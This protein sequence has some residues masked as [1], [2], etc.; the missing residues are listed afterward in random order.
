MRSPRAVRKMANK[1]GGVGGQ[2]VE[3]VNTW[4]RECV[5]AVHVLQVHAHT[6]IEYAAYTTICIISLCL[7][8]TWT[9]L[10][11]FRMRAVRYVWPRNHANYSRHVY[12]CAIYYIFEHV[13][14]VRVWMIRRYNQPTFVRG[15]CQPSQ[16]RL[17][18]L[19]VLIF[20]S[21]KS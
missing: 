6:H 10:R 14:I 8:H 13:Y 16:S 3:C 20:S 7:V 19:V 11:Y 12:S 4:M 17:N 18:V 21:T 9:S 2:K 5:P 15:E 1:R